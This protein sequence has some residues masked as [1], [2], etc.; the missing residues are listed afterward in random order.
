MKQ[1]TMIMLLLSPALVWAQKS[2]KQDIASIKAMTGCYKV[3]FNFAETFSPQRDYEYHDNYASHAY[4]YVALI[5]DGSDKLSLQHLLVIR[6]T[7]VIKH[8]RQDWIF[9]DTDLYTYDKDKTWK[10]VTLSKEEA[11]GQWTQEVYQV[12]DSPRYEGSS[13]WIHV[14]GRNYWENTTDAPLPRR[15]YTKRDD[16]NVMVRRNRQEITEEGWVHEQDNDKVLRADGSDKLIAQEKGMNNYN[17]ADE[18]KCA[19]AKTWWAENGAFWA[20]VRAV[21]AEVFDTRKTLAFE[22]KVDEKHLYERLFALQDDFKGDHDSEKTKAEIRKAIQ[23]YI[24]G[25]I[26]LASK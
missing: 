3:Y 9:Q 16:Y 7:M 26:Q 18:S 19:A 22:T 12:D 23:L 8:W 15:E 11:K 21:W 24:K 1:L 6:D 17:K 2:K 10:P 20:D 25:D 4:E 13:S 5:E 14:D